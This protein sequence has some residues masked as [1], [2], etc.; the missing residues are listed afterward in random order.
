[1]NFK[2]RGTQNLQDYVDIM[3]NCKGCRIECHQLELEK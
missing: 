3:Y 2:E 1:M